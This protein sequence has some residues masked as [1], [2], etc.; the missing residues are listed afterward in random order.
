MFQFILKDA[1]SF[2]N[3]EIR[4]ER[5]RERETE[6]EREIERV[7][8]IGRERDSSMLLRVMYICDWSIYEN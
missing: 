3:E 6:R 1:I 8:E 4:K 2:I 5:D 7:G